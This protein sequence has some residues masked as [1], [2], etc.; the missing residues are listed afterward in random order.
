[1]VP[2]AHLRRCRPDG[3]V[4]SILARSVPQVLRLSLAY[5]L[6]DRCPG[7]DEGHLYAALWRYAEDTAGWLFGGQLDTGAV[8]DLLA[9][10]AAGGR[11]GRTR[12]QISIEHYQRHRTADEIDA[13]LGGLIRDGRVQQHTDRSGQGRPVTRYYAL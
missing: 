10:I 8:D 11:T 2:S 7:I 12:S 9:Y 1:M 3:P 13:T 6:V 4:A 5:A